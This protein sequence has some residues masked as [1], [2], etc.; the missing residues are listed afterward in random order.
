MSVKVQRR[1]VGDVTI[2]DIAGRVTLGE[3]SSMF[4]DVIKDLT[5][6]GRKKILLNLA[7]VAY[8]DSSGLGELVSGFTMVANRGGSLKLLSL[9]KRLK[10]LLYGVTKL[11]TVFEIHDNEAQALRSFEI[12]PL[13]CLCPVCSCRSSPALM[14]EPAWPPQ[15]C[16]NSACGTRFTLV[17]CNSSPGL[18][19]IERARIQTYPGEYFEVIAGVPFRVQIAGR[20]NLFAL[21][22]FRKAWEALPSVKVIFD[23]HLATEISG[24]G[25]TALLG[26][27]PSPGKQGKSVIS[28]EGVAPELGKTLLPAPLVYPDDVSAVAALGDLSKRPHWPARFA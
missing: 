8:I 21:S 23:L 22:A 13:H 14:D 25:F 24:A 10:D 11:Y 28:L 17:P 1:W 9:T 19:L 20:L 26:L 12:S 27:L 18:D 6:H 3:G 2:L 16:G 4:R 15:T 7:E 5:L